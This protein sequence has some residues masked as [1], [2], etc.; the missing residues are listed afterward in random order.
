MSHLDELDETQRAAVDQY[1]KR[2]SPPHGTADRNWAAIEAKLLDQ[3][4]PAAGTEDQHAGVVPLRQASA[5]ASASSSVADC[6]LDDGADESVSASR[7]TPRLRVAIV[8]TLAIAAA[9]ALTITDVGQS[10]ISSGKRAVETG[11]YAALWDRDETADVASAQ[12]R[13]PAPRRAVAAPRPEAMTDVAAVLDDRDVEETTTP[14]EVVETTP[15]PSRPSKRLRRTKSEPAPQA[16]SSPVS[17]ST[18]R[19]EARLLS[20]A[21]AAL[22]DD[23]P[24]RA[25]ELLDRH[26]SMFSSGALA[27]ERSVLRVQVLCDLGQADAARS[28][29]NSFRAAHPRSPLTSRLAKTCAGK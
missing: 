27:P 4:H 22:R 2:V 3:L 13:R 15:E 21:R 5:C 29:A 7:A 9:L 25:L 24:H 19:Q 8:S 28:A 10:V 1:R 11:N 16:E 23:Q 18:L 12:H 17:A 6:V 26:T 14:E 20:Q